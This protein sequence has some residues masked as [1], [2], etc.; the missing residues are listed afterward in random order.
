M[1]Q[2]QQEGYE[3]LSVPIR[4]LVLGANWF[5]WMESCTKSSE[6]IAVFFRYASITFLDF[7]WCSA[8]VVTR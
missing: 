4:Y 3:R 2:Q 8:S 7:L 5:C 6:T 1:E